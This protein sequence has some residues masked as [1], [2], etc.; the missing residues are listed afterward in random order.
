MN[1]EFT[2]NTIKQKYLPS[3]LDGKTF[4]R[5]AQAEVISGTLSLD[6]VHFR[7]TTRKNVTK[8]VNVNP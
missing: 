8:C 1:E 7:Y 4:P 2:D 5:L 6:N 3:L